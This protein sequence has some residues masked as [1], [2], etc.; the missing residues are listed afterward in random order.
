MAEIKL[1]GRVRIIW[2]LPEILTIAVIWIIGISL[3]FL[4][5]YEVGLGISKLS[6][7][8]ILVGLTVVFGLP[9][10]AMVELRYR[11]FKYE[12]K[13]NEVVIRWGVINRNRTVV[14]YEKI[15]NVRAVRFLAERVLGIARVMIETA[16]G[17]EQGMSEVTIPGIARS[18]AFVEELM[19][20]SNTAKKEGKL[21]IENVDWSG[22]GDTREIMLS[23]LHETK[24]VLEEIRRIRT[25]LEKEKIEREK[26]KKI[27]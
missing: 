22:E 10:F 1:D 3:I 19:E 27:K 11:A 26:N 23:Q 6:A 7:L 18:R 2:L 8:Y 24:A 4:V 17:I 12:L 13:A 5:S 20:R 16:G 21:D 14:P 25:L 9:A 15:Q